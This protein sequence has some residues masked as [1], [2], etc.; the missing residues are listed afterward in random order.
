MMTA[1]TIA[2]RVWQHC[3]E[4]A[5][6]LV[7]VCTL[8]FSFLTSDCTAGDD[9]RVTSL[10][11]R[12][13]RNVV[14]DLRVRRDSSSQPSRIAVISSL[15]VE[16]VPRAI[17]NPF[18]RADLGRPFRIVV[19]DRGDRIIRT[20]VRQTEIRL[21]VDTR[22]W[23]IARSGAVFGSCHWIESGTSTTD[24]SIEVPKLPAGR[25]A[26][27]A[28]YSSR[29]FH[30]PP[31]Q[32]ENELERWTQSWTDPAQDEPCCASFPVHFE[33]DS[34]RE[35]QW[36]HASDEE[37]EWNPVESDFRVES[38]ERV[39]ITTRYI[40]PA[41]SSLL[42]PGLNVSSPYRGPVRF[43]IRNENPKA[44]SL[45]SSLRSGSVVADSVDAVPVPRDAVV[46]G[47]RTI[48]IDQPGQYRIVTQID[49]SIYADKVFTMGKRNRSAYTI[50]PVV[51]TSRPKTVKVPGLPK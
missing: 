5:E 24:N 40:N 51:L 10:P 49:E 23:M 25:Y 34:Q 20:L 8:F 19:T 22:N 37:F 11:V 29:M 32:G 13:D 35:L 50:W 44:D 26:L 45:R 39:I 16:H 18:G 38:G 33:V 36:S 27:V 15:V 1:E 7:F 43:E 12:F 4:H 3:M 2:Q 46:G 21:P 31:P 6:W 28:L 41:E 47:T 9:V 17:F 30:D 14:P 48:L 42:L